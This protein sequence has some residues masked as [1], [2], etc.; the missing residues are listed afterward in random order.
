LPWRLPSPLCCIVYRIGLAI[1]TLCPLPLVAGF[2]FQRG[3]GFDTTPAQAI[4]E[5][6]H[7]V[8]DSRALLERNHFSG[9]SI[10]PD[11]RAFAYVITQ[12]D[13][14]TNKYRTAFVLGSIAEPLAAK[15][16]ATAGRPAWFY[17]GQYLAIDPQWSPDS[18]TVS[19]IRIMNDASQVWAADVG[20]RRLRQLTNSPDDV[21]CHVWLPGS[22]EIGIE[23]RKNGRN[24]LGPS[25]DA[26]FR[27]TDTMMAKASIPFLDR[28]EE[29][30]PRSEFLV[31]DSIR[32]ASRAPSDI[33]RRFVDSRCERPF[34]DVSSSLNVLTSRDGKVTAKIQ[35]IPNRTRYPDANIKITDSHTG[36]EIASFGP[37]KYAELVGW[38]KD[39][40]HLVF[41]LS[42][43][44]GEKHVFVFDSD[45]RAIR[46]I[47][48]N[49]ELT[50]FHN[51]SLAQQAAI[52][53]CW[54]ESPDVLTQLVAVHLDSGRIRPI[55]NPNRA[56]QDAV[57]AGYR[58]ER[59]VWRSSAGEIFEWFLMVPLVERPVSGYPTVIAT[60]YFGNEFITSRGEEVPLQVLTRLGFAVVCLSVIPQRTKDS[61]FADA[62]RDWDAPLEAMQAIV[63]GLSGERLVDAHRVGII[64]LSYGAELVEH[65]ISRSKLFAAASSGGGGSHDPPFLATI[66]LEK[67]VWPL[68]GFPG[69]WWDEGV[70][71]E[72]WR[73][74]SP[75]M[76]AADI[77]TP[78]LIQAADREALNTV[79]MYSQLR[80]FSRPVE[81]WVFPDERH[82]KWW[83]KNKLSANERNIAWFE[84]W[85]MDRCQPT[86]E[87]SSQCERWRELRNGWRRH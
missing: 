13:T 47:S 5:V 20:T 82:V 42:L 66:F 70:G 63:E 75:M 87:D 23:V 44:F 57:K 17:V 39:D 15:V 58:L 64:G 77:E 24:T 68:Y 11:G 48:G 65:A 62:L 22:R 9:A 54:A 31:V 59:R 52:A 6:P 21:L 60:Y 10:S 30:H 74:Y 50:L 19:L 37:G 7:G 28:A 49:S 12:M 83:P 86:P 51:C 8:L 73:T 29:T 25:R 79:P 71:L 18:K 84:F 4:N 69:I 35:R 34:R 76:R 40:K 32:G 36:G 56:L 1:A 2:S 16:I 33:E 85:L 46:Q 3:P 53:L 81:F 43:R 61:S 67:E 27:W 78:L 72:K 38:S 26:P 41:L 14:R 80:R 45:K 55:A